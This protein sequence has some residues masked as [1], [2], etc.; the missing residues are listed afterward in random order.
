MH[1]FVILVGV[2]VLFQITAFT[3]LISAQTP[4]HPFMLVS[5][6][7]LPALRARASQEPWSSMKADAI[8]DCQNLTYSP[9]DLQDYD[10]GYRMQNIMSAC[11]LAFILDDANRMQYKQKILNVMPMW[12]DI[13]VVQRTP[14]YSAA[15]FMAPAAAFLDSILAMDIIYN[16]LTLAEKTS[17]EN[18]LLQ[19]YN[20]YY[21]APPANPPAFEGTQLVWNIYKGKDA[22]DPYINALVK[23]GQRDDYRP[24]V[25]YK[26]QM[27]MLFTPDGVYYE[28]PFYGTVAFAHQRG[29]RSHI[30]DIL[31]HTNIIR[32]IDFDGN[33]VADNYSFYQDPKYQN[34]YEWLFG[35]ASTPAGIQAPFGDSSDFYPVW[36]ENFG[37][38]TIHTAHTGQA[39]KFSQEAGQYAMWRRTQFADKPSQDPIFLPG[40][41]LQ[42]VLLS[43]PLP[44][45]TAPISRIF[46][47]GGAFFMDHN[48]TKNSLY[49]A[50][51]NVK[52][53][54]EYFNDPN[55]VYFHAHN[56]TNSIHVSAYGEPLLLNVGFKGAGGAQGADECLGFSTN[57]MT[58][59]AVGNNTALINYNI[60]NPN[61]PSEANDHRYKFGAGISEGF[62]G[63]G[64]DYA[65]GD[66]GLALPNGKHQRNFIFVHPQIGSNG[67]FIL[68]DEITG[69][70]GTST[71]HIALHPNSD[72]TAAVSSNQEY[73][74]PIPATPRTCYDPETGDPFS[75]S[76]AFTNQSAGISVFLATPPQRVDLLDGALCHWEYYDDHAPYVGKYIFSTYPLSSSRKNIVTVVFPYD[77]THA[78]AG[79]SRLSGSNY[80][81]ASVQHPASIFDTALESSAPTS[82][83]RHD[84]VTFRGKAV[85]YRT[86]NSQTSAYFVR[87]GSL[88]RDSATPQRGFEA[89]NSVSLYMSDEGG[90]VISQGSDITFYRPGL[91]TIYLNGQAQTPLSSG[92]DWVRIRIS[93]GSYQI[94]F[95]NQSSSTPIPTLVPILGDANNDRRVDGIDYVIWLNHYGVTTSNGSSDADFNS[96]GRVDGVDYVIWLNNYGTQ[97]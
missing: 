89:T 86:Q 3:N 28:G 17:A 47:D 18:W 13:L 7:Q 48:L 46:N 69:N 61:D 34:L 64:I 12:A 95:N 44:A 53:T 67:Y 76:V 15:F 70:A 62:T 39:S 6:D 22:S 25:G 87:Q 63:N 74:A 72:L 43:Y 26:P 5:A 75:C 40:R 33:G 16:D 79:F 55:M 27:D 60:G 35:Y 56:D 81:G 91:I 8:F 88:F 9:D 4:A 14:N 59:R 84:L 42:Y 54:E 20:H 80:T 92:T 37:Y 77:S 32:N 82:D 58:H 93:S 10:K 45:P 66:S 71:A 94:A 36:S 57:Y 19:E 96:D 73:R 78:A 31:E 2:L 85:W 29:E 1:T 21:N 50:L 11:S 51:W 90:N 24:I 38:Y 83:I 41:L 52:A 49:G 65:S 23:G 30:I 68:F 97:L